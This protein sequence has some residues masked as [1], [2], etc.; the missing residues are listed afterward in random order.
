MNINTNLKKDSPLFRIG[1]F[2]LK[3]PVTHYVLCKSKLE[4][5][6]FTKC[7]QTTPYD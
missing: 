5:D 4:L 3:G 7:G 2:P 1:A 6:I